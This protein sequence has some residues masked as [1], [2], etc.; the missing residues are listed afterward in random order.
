MRRPTIRLAILLE[1]VAALA[2]GMAVYRW[3]GPL[4]EFH[5]QETFWDY[6][7]VKFPAILTGIALVE[8]TVLGWESIRRRGPS[9]WGIG[10]W[11][12]TISGMFVVL[13]SLKSAAYIGES[14]YRG[15]LEGFTRST[16]EILEYVETTLAEIWVYG[17]V[18]EFSMAL[19]AFAVASRLARLP[20]DPAPDAREWSGR[21]FAATLIGWVAL[22]LIRR[23]AF[24][25]A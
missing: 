14:C 3:V 2:V 24:D 23:L 13:D 25:L 1:W 18:G 6:F 11:S 15:R 4:I 10:R 19:L 8:S 5:N 16:E 21:I 22:K 17:L 12:L 20:M 7:I 9:S